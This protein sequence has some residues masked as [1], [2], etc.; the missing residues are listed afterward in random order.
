MVRIDRRANG[1][2]AKHAVSSGHGLPSQGFGQVPKG[3]RELPFGLHAA[4]GQ[5]EAKARTV[6]RPP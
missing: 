3:S 4:L 5:A 2:H 6:K 1:W